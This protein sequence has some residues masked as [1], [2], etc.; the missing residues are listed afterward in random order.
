MGLGFRVGFRKRRAPLHEPLNPL[1]FELVR[2]FEKMKAHV[3]SPPDK[4]YNLGMQGNPCSWTYFCSY[5]SR[6][7]CNVNFRTNCLITH[8]MGLKVSP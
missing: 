2:S 8:S 7:R 4:A 3:G 1:L 6:C 5:A